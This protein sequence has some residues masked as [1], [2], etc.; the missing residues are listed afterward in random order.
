MH[1]QK[2]EAVVEPICANAGQQKTILDEER[3]LTKCK[4]PSHFI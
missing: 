2:S 3:Y 4:S 1:I